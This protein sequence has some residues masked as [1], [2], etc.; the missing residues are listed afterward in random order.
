MR[1]SFGFISMLI[2]FVLLGIEPKDLPFLGKCFV[3]ELR[4]RSQEFGFIMNFE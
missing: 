2:L 1:K 4:G 3:T